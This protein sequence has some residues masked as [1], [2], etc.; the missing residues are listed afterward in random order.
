MIH[1]LF[2]HYIC[3]YQQLKNNNM[4]DEKRETPLEENI[5]DKD[6]I[7]EN[8]SCEISSNIDKIDKSFELEDDEFDSF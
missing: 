2:Y 7:I 6:E 1:S 5:N 4:E 8:S 3:L